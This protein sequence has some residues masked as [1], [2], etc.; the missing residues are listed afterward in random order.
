MA[1]SMIAHCSGDAMYF[2]VIDVLLKT[3]EEWLFDNENPIKIIK[4]CT[5]SWLI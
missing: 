5:F 2:G 4:G 1:G 3:Q